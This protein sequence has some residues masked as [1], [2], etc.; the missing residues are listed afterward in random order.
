M[1]GLALARGRYRRRRVAGVA[2][3]FRRCARA[4]LYNLRAFAEKLARLHAGT[5]ALAGA[6]FADIRQLAYT[7]LLE[8]MDGYDT[9]R[10]APFAAYAK[11]R[12]A[13]AIKDGIA[14]AS[15]RSEQVSWRRTVARERGQSL[16][17]GVSEADASPLEK[18]A[19][20]AA[21]LAIGFMLEETG[22]YVTDSRKAA[23]QAAP[24]ESAVWQDMLKQL[25]QQLSALPRRE[26]TILRQHYLKGCLSDHLAA[27]MGITRG[28]IA[29]APRGAGSVAK[30]NGRSR[31]FRLES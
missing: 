20:I 19:E 18:L 16:S 9:A 24:Y 8:A 29:A 10:G 25:S 14:R 31:H 22:M 26:Q 7:G 2:C 28:G 3:G 30:A 23:P 6:D 27:M 17:G 11:H 12:I 21:G 5:A 1:P 13:G 15:E 4:D